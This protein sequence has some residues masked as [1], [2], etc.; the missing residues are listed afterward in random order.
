MSIEKDIKNNGMPWE[1][2][3]GFVQAIKVGN[4]IHISGQ[5][6]H[7]DNG[8]IVGAAPIDNEGNIL[9]HSNMAVQMRQTYL[10]AKQILSHYGA[11]LDHVVEEVV[12]VTS[13][14]QVLAIAG[15]IRKE[16]YGTEKPQ[17]CCTLLTTPR[18]AFPEQLI[19]I[20]FVAI[21]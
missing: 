3:F 6:S 5:F 19:E 11:T 2:S 18:L 8:N 10:N 7:D 21:V 12:Y 9:D 14:D 1:D 15:E 4:M 20:K 16:M 17:V 13:I